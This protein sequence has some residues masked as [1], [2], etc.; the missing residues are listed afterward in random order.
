MEGKRRSLIGIGFEIA[1]GAAV[2]YSAIAAIAAGAIGTTL[3]VWGVIDWWR[4]RR[5]KP[6]LKVGSTLLTIGVVGATAFLFIAL[7]GL[8]WQRFIEKPNKQAEQGKPPTLQ[9]TTQPTIRLSDF[10][11]GFER[12]PGYF[13]IGM[14]ADADKK[15]L[16]HFFQAQGFNRTKDPI[17]KVHAYVRSDRTNVQYPIYFNLNGK[18]AAESEIN[19]IPVDAIIDIRA[20][21][22]PNDGLIPV[23]QFLDETVPFTFFFEY[24]GKQYRRTFT[25][26][27]IEPLIRDYE[28]TVRKSSV[29]PPQMTAKSPSKS[30]PAIPVPTPKDSILSGRPVSGLEVVRRLEQVENELDTTK[31]ALAEANKRLTDAGQPRSPTTKLATI[32]AAPPKPEHKRYTAYEKEQRLRAVDEIY[33]VIATQL[34]PTYGDG[35]KLLDQIYKTADVGAEQRLPEY[36]AKVQAAFD[37]LNTLLKKYNYFTDIVQAA[38]KNTFN[39]VEATHQAGNLITELRDLRSRAP[40]DVQWFLLRDTTML[41]ARNQSTRFGRYIAETLPLLQEKR[42]EIEK[43]E[44]YS[45]Q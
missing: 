31:N 26:D 44:V 28:Q 40:N 2:N 8:A 27:E 14:S 23:Q 5:G 17:T 43:A 39:D 30:L 45:G 38:T 24:D 11:W 21:F 20:P 3:I 22:L 32:D 1:G 9:E 18:R 37:N 36:V 41:D 33:N 34:Q 10:E 6:R 42:A 15:I 35:R 13:F 25:L 7:A 16:V 19:P 4:E 12:H 29:K